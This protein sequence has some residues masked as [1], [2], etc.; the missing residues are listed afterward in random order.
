MQTIGEKLEE[1]RKRRG[2]SV[3]EA[4]EVTKIRG[5]YLASFESNSFDINLPEVYIRGFLR[6]YALFLK[7]NA[8]KIL[9]DY[10]AHQLGESAFARPKDSREFLGRMDIPEETGDEGSAAA[11]A[12]PPQRQNIP[13]SQNEDES[14][15]NYNNFDKASLIKGSAA[16]AGAGVLVLAVIL[17]IMTVFRSSPDDETVANGTAE[18]TGQQELT[19]IANGGDIVNITATELGTDQ[20]LFRG[21][22]NEG[23]SQTVP[24]TEQVRLRFTDAEYLNIEYEGN[25]SGFDRRGPGR[26]TFPPNAP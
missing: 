14:G 2:I 12:P 3:R 8:D 20:E 21:S 18:Q 13:S 11:V 15:F 23:D 26:V 25:L 19:L 16:I 1:A 9:T 10:N 5:D 7:L 6:N 17:L 24:F 4:S 22:L